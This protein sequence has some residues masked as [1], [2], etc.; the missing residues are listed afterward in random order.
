[1]SAAH[2][3]WKA[4][5]AA[6]LH[7]SAE[8]ALVLLRDPEGHAGGTVARLR[9]QL[10]G[11]D[12]LER[13]LQEIVQKADWWAAAADRPQFPLEADN[14]RAR[15]TRVSFSEQPILIHPL[16]GTQ[17]D[18]KSLQDVSTDAIKAVS[19]D[20][21]QDLIVHADGAVDWRR[22][23]LRFWRLGSERPAP[24]LGALWGVLPADTR[25]PDHSIWEHLR[26][27]SA[28]AGIFAL[29]ETPALLSVS[30]GPVQ[31]FIAQSRTTSDLWAGSH[32]LSRLAWEGGPSTQDRRTRETR[33]RNV[34]HVPGPAGS[35]G[36]RSDFAG[37]GRCFGHAVE[38]RSAARHRARRSAPNGPDGNAL[39]H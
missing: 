34:A 22:T 30:L 38:Q 9:K 32:L 23:F 17:Y 20:H 4:K 27:T 33:G 37:P 29:G 24:E 25:I 35:S 6:F 15:W 11:S 12:T 3:T 1:M 18:L 39:H 21:F 26:L 19:L 36:S 13:S 14:R 28:F 31:S 8:K 7:D 5:V 2:A 10:F 16:S